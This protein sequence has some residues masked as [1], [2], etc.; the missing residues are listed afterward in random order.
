MWDI[1]IFFYFV[2]W[3]RWRRIKFFEKKEDIYLDD[4]DERLFFFFILIWRGNELVK[5]LDK[6]FYEFG[7]G[8]ECIYNFE[9][10]GEYVWIEMIVEIKFL[11]LFFFLCIVLI[12]FSSCGGIM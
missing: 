5:N 8:F 2:S 6:D 11:C 10:R 4:E 3:F 9:N 7:E 1:I 12:N